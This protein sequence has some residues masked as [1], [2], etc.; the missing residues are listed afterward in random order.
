[1]ILMLVL[2]EYLS[3]AI[4]YMNSVLPA[5]WCIHECIHYSVSISVSLDQYLTEDNHKV[6]RIASLLCRGQDVLLLLRMQIR[7][8]A[9]H[10]NFLVRWRERKWFLIHEAINSR[11]VRLNNIV[12]GDRINRRASIASAMLSAQRARSLLMEYL[13]RRQCNSIAS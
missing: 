4:V 3:I 12:V 11:Y 5:A 10:N 2:D 7:S 1:M 8:M 6:V 13:K 9:E